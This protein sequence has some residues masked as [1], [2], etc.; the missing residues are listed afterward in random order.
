MPAVEKGRAPSCTSTPASPT[1]K[2]KTAEGD[3]STALAGRKQIVAVPADCRTATIVLTGRHRIIL[4]QV[5]GSVSD[6]HACLDEIRNNITRGEHQ[7]FAENN[8]AK[9]DLLGL[10]MQV[11]GTTNFVK[12]PGVRAARHRAQNYHRPVEGRTRRFGVAG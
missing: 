7:F 4:A 8:G 2:K 11:R 9:G 6:A 10:L 5:E 1:A 12:S 3:I